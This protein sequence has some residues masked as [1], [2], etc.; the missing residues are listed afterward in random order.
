M[1][2]HNTNIDS[3][4][5]IHKETVEEFLSRGGKITQVPTGVALPVT[6]IGMIHVD[7]E[8]IPISTGEFEYIPSFV[9]S[10]QT[11]VDAQNQHMTGHDVGLPQSWKEYEHSTVRR[12]STRQAKS[13]FKEDE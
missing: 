11:Y 6:E 1:K 13:F 7:G 9:V 3:P 12:V 5:Y 8:S 10:E 2:R 4:D